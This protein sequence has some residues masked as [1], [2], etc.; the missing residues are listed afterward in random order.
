MSVKLVQQKIPIGSH[1]RFTLK[2][3]K[4]IQGTLVE[5]GREHITVE[6]KDNLTTILTEMLGAWEILESENVPTGIIRPDISSEV[7]NRLIIV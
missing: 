7:I 5:I 2:N 1:V 4:E 6:T 3:G